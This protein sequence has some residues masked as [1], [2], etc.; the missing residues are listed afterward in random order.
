[1]NLFNF[2]TYSTTANTNTNTAFE[3]EPVRDD[4]LDVTELLGMQ[5][6]T[7]RRS[8]AREEEERELALKAKEKLHNLSERYTM[9]VDTSAL[10]HSNFPL[11]VEHL[12]PVLHETGKSL[13]VPFCVV[14]ELKNT[15]EGNSTSAGYAREAIHLLTE[16][17]RDGL[18]EICGEA[19]DL[20][21][22]KQKV[23]TV[24]A[25]MQRGEVLVITQSRALSST[26]MD[27]SRLGLAGE[28]H[29]GISQINK[30]GYLSRF[31]SNSKAIPTTPHRVTP[32]V[33]K[34][35]TCAD[36]GETFS[37]LESERDY[38][39]RNGLCLPRRCPDCRKARKQT[40]C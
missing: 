27:V 31:I 7:D 20:T 13:L 29:V 3:T 21:N 28:G 32:R 2:N 16:L 22:L 5:P 25:E 11:L 37:I 34:H 33:W 17:K 15:A 39:Q 38:F 23:A 1:M 10:T 35:E 6:P 40:A 4:R 24:L 36:C 9:V 14:L 26:L 12:R 19:S 30:H 18:A 8:A